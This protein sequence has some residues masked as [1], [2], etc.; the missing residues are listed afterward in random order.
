MSL[1][2]K[3]G[4]QF[5][6]ILANYCVF[7]SLNG[8]GLWKVFQNWT[9][10]IVTKN[11]EWVW[12][13]PGFH[14]RHFCTCVKSFCSVLRN[15]LRPLFKDGTNWLLVKSMYSTNCDPGRLYSMKIMN[16][17]SSHFLTIRRMKISYILQ[18]IN[19]KSGVF[20]F[21]FFQQL[22]CLF[23]SLGFKSKTLLAIL[24]YPGIILIP[25]TTFWTFS[26]LSIKSCLKC[27]NGGRKIGVSMIFTSVNLFITLIGMYIYLHSYPALK[28]NSF[29]CRF[30]KYSC[31]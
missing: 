19:N 17:N 12:N 18:C 3:I 30:N 13:C 16:Q 9:L 14:Q 10:S 27:K 4:Y 20:I 15:R 26:G 5:Y 22:I 23:G 11:K 28:L 29:Q 7:I 24:D 31:K 6:A 21:L 1:G 25:A 8:L 2:S